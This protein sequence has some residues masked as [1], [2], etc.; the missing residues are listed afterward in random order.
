MVIETLLFPEEVLSG[1]YE[2]FIAHRRYD[3]HLLRAVYEYEDGLPML[4]TIYFPY[5]ERYFLGNNIYEDTIL[6]R[7]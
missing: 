6:K 7:N 2:R 3:K 5:S 1:H 4:I